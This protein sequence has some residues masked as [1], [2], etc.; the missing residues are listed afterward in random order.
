[1]EV[2]ETDEL[3]TKV[4]NY[5]ERR[6]YLSAE[7]QGFREDEADIARLVERATVLP[8][9]ASAESVVLDLP[10]AEKQFTK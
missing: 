1:M 10:T 4:L 3:T 2:F 7:P 9:S 5:F 8:Y 6:N